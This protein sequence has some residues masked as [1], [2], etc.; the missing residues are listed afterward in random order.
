[1][2]GTGQKQEAAS[3]AAPERVRAHLRAILAHAE[4]AASPQLS[5]FLSY[6]VERKLEGSDERIKAYA[7][8]TE[9]LGRP[10]SFDAQTDPIVR[11]QAGRLRQA[12]QLYYA[13]PLADDSVRIS[14]P[15]GGYAPDIVACDGPPPPSATLAPPKP[16]RR[17]RLALAGGLLAIAAALWAA[18]PS[19]REDLAQFIWRKPAAQTNPLGMPDLA[20][21][22]ASAQQIPSWFQ[23]GL[24]RRGLEL[25]LSRFD[26]FVV[27]SGGDAAAKDEADFH[28]DLDF[29]GNTSAV[30]GTARLTRGSS[31]HIVWTASFAIPEDSIDS[32]ELI[33]PVRRLASTLGQPYGVLYAQLLG[34]PAKT[35]DQ[36]CLLSSYEWYQHPAREAIEPVR[37]CLEDLLHRNPGNHIGYIMLGYIYVERYRNRL[38]SDP[39]ADLAHALTMAKRAVALRPESAGSQQVMM[40]VQSAR[41]HADLALEAGQKA[42]ALNPNDSDVLADYGC[43]L[44]YRGRYSEGLTYAER[45]ARWNPQPPPWHQFCL[46]L[47]ANNTGHFADAERIAAALDG[48]EGPDAL[49]PVAI[50]AWRRGDRPHAAAALQALVAY[51]SRFATDPATPLSQFGLFPEVTRAVVAD[52]TQATLTAGK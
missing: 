33:D 7:I 4:F 48:L 45:A 16:R 36:Q 8:A 28:L 49:V 38:G 26:E 11:V 43:R 51:D 30:V 40:E 44:I 3:V 17:L 34:D 10:A 23:P 29:T 13:D 6:I 39:A 46:F 27:F 42:L 1:M 15:V 31:R 24:F 47:A 37:L 9:A 32:Y 22:V 5:A 19:F 41:G 52:L 14:L 18:V 2:S 21:S 25:D 35:A 50:A 20:V 12:L